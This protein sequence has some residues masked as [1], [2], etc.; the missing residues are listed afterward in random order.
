MLLLAFLALIP[1]FILGFLL[2]QW[3]WKSSDVKD[4]I[5]KIFLAGPVGVGVS[6][7]LSFLW[8][9]AKLDLRVYAL[10][11]TVVVLLLLAYIIWKQRFS[12]AEFFK[13]VRF[14]L[15]KANTIWIILFG[16]AL[17]IFI[18][19]FWINAVQNPHGRW[20]AWSNWN[21]VA[22]F[23]YRGGQHWT[24]TFL[25]IYDHPDYPFLLTMANATTWELLPKETDRGPMVLA[26]VFTICVAGLLFSFINTLRDSETAALAT[27]VLMTQPMVAYN[28]MTQFADLPEAYYF[29]A[30][31]G[32]ILIYL[33]KR[34]RT[35]PILAGL[36]TGLGMWTKNEGLTFAAIN[37]AAWIIIA[38]TKERSAF[39]NFLIGIAL[40][41]AVVFLFKVF[42]APGNDLVTNRQN[43]L[44]LIEDISRYEYIIQKT[45][46]E[47]WN[48]GQG[49]ISIIA[50]LVLYTLLTGKTK[51]PAEGLSYALLI[52][53][54]QLLIYFSVY[55]I[56]PYDL[57]WHI[58]T[59]INRLY[60]HVFPIV[61]LILFLWLKS[62]SELI[63]PSSEKQYAPHN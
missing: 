13:S 45:S 59:S 40:P 9:W 15:T 39:K 32:L 60:M 58:R 37:A 57:D 6:S 3:I 10:V 55:V 16:V 11:E 52:V 4:L 12:I 33:F 46:I 62:P 38:W 35:I 2:V 51:S 22:R 63:A 23:V 29:L 1:R 30:S 48:V 42:L 21:V 26:F 31:V 18:G 54:I 50:I 56:T 34:E 7:L 44:K 14:S 41:L 27:I 28:G 61:I 20:D 49:P 17:L 47:L 36:V 24:G 53:L 43:I 25:R 19:E 8:I 5:V